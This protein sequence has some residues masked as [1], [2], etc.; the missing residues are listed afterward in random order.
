M[1]W[2]SLVDHEDGFVLM[3]RSA[4]MIPSVPDYELLRRI[5]AGAY[6]EIWLARSLATGA[7]RAAKVVR[8]DKFD[9]DRPFQREFEGIQRFERISR[10]HPTQLALFHIGR[11]EAAGYF[12][13]IMELADAA[14]GP[15]PEVR[16]PNSAVRT[17]GA[18][19]PTLP[20]GLGLRPSDAY[21]PHTLRADLE[22]GRIPAVRVLEI[23]LALTEAL[24]NLH[25]H[26]LVHRDV[27]PSNV[28]FIDG[29]PKLADI[30]LVTDTGD[31]RSIVGTEGYLAP[32]GPGAP[33]ADLFA[34]GKVLYEAATGLDRRR[35]P[36]LPP[37]VRT[38]LDASK[39]LELNEIIVKACA[40]R[41]EE[42]YR[43]AEEMQA[44]LQLLKI[45]QS[46]KHLRRVERRLAI[47]SRAAVLLSLCAVVASGVVYYVYRQNQLSLRSLV[48]LHVANGTQLLNDGDL[49]GSLLS[50]TEALRLDAG[51]WKRE[52]GHRIRIASVL[53]ECPKL[54]GMFAQ[55]DADINDAAFSADSQRV[56]T[57]S[58]DHTAQMWELAT[59]RPTFS[60]LH[61]GAVFSVAISPD[62]KWIATTSSDNLVHLWDSQSGG[63][64]GAATMRHRAWH[65]G[66]CPEISPDGTRVLT[67]P[68][69]HTVQIWNPV[70]GMKVGVP[71]RHDHEVSG[72]MFSPD[73]RLV[74]TLSAHRV[75]QVWDAATGEVVYSL[76]HEGIVNCGAF[77]SDGRLVATGGDDDYVRIWDLTTGRETEALLQRRPV[78]SL[79][80]SPDGGR[81][82]AGCRDRTVELWDLATKRALL[83]PLQHDQRVLR[84]DFSPDGRW[85]C[86]ST[87]GNR[88]RFW[89]SDSG[90]LL[91]PPFV[92]DTPRRPVIFSPD[93]HLVLTLRHDLTLERQELAVIWD[94]ARKQAPPLRIR[95]MLTFRHKAFSPDKRYKAI[96]N[97]NVVR[98]L[99]NASG[100]PLTQALKQSTPFR[101]A[102]F[103]RDNTV[104]LTESVGG[105]GELWDLSGGDPLTPKL[106]IVYDAEA[107]VPLKSELAHAVGSTEE[108]VAQAELLSGNR[109]D[110]AGGFGP[111]DRTEL[112]DRWNVLKRK[113]A[114]ESSDLP[115]ETLAWQEQQAKDCEQAWNWWS[116]L[117]YLKILVAARPSDQTLAQRQA[118]AE[119]ALENAT[120]KA[121]GYFAQRYFVI[122]PRNPQAT[123]GMI[124]L[125]AY[126]N[127][128]KRVGDNS[129]ATLPSGLQAFA[130]TAFDVRG[131]VQ[132]SDQVGPAPLSPL[133]NA[134]RGIQVNRTCRK[135]HFLHATAS[136]VMD[137]TNEVSSYFVHYVDGR[138]QRVVNI[139]GRDVRAWWT[140]GNES[141]TADGATLV[142]MGTNPGVELDDA[143]SLRMFKR[144]WNNPWPDVEVV[145]IDF[146]SNAKGVSPFLVALTAE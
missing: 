69:V 138:T 143:G 97:G 43:C 116:A 106:R 111:L 125:T 99:V 5:G 110:E 19:S 94:L 93:G 119:L 131:V 36:R 46:V 118:Y 128:S 60:L 45:D 96:L 17:E 146:I 33:S 3:T 126:Y 20:S 66:P 61:T 129:M 41:P 71:L 122:P 58:D 123:A 95:P 2:R 103:S 100:K 47:L 142:W 72:F 49:F 124:D 51:N 67:L 88:V 28:I 130:G 139:Y 35:F 113:R 38:W 7:L 21:L 90:E 31:R 141:L 127:R 56:I 54:V 18:P 85:V 121:P 114:E 81:L 140:T 8:R 80:F 64:L 9:D 22:R 10:G 53:R 108:L 12:Y 4:P 135:L 102:C 92:Q 98:T 23:G 84:T 105:R 78:D 145:S 63:P 25:G 13:Y 75:A 15:E 83:R 70:T 16:A 24:I 57:A 30:G 39:V 76:N 112:V 120:R 73:S 50:F 29:R 32:E 27:K 1:P 109:V 133:T 6:G 79:A 42:R 59:G 144:S 132:L 82:A 52:E 86:V 62:G 37:D 91:A 14:E 11:N 107:K 89:D 74:L 55:S 87:E 104:L 40:T 34:L 77:G 117:F 136:R 115:A 68:D 65:N 44:D 137:G 101:Q 134:V 26:G 48:R